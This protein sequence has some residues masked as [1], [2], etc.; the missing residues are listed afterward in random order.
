M[1]R[2]HILS[3][4]RPILLDNSRL[5]SR[6][7][8]HLC[9]LDTQE[10]VVTLPMVAFLSH[11]SIERQMAYHILSALVIL[12]ASIVATLE[13]LKTVRPSLVLSA[14]AQVGLCSRGLVLLIQMLMLRCLRTMK[15][16]LIRTLL[17]IRRQHKKSQIKV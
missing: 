11:F 14:M 6:L 12:F 4:M 2:V 10:I 9:I 13:P 5:T 16:M 8:I 1:Q 17:I 3:P 7:L 15:L